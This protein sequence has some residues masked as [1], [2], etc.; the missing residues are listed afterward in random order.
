MMRVE[1]I[2]QSSQEAGSAAGGTGQSQRHGSRPG[3]PHDQG[4]PGS[5]T[6]LPNSTTLDPGRRQRN[7]RNRPQYLGRPVCNPETAI[8]VGKFSSKEK[9]ARRR[10]KEDCGRNFPRVDSG[11]KTPR[12]F[13]RRQ[14]GL[15]ACSSGRGK[16]DRR[17][18]RSR[19]LRPRAQR[20]Q[21]PCK[22]HPVRRSGE[23][24]PVDL[25]FH[26]PF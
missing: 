14:Q 4:E 21:R 20:R 12:K 17:K 16:S 7:P 22:E 1:Q 13:G 10:S 2:A 3:S 5:V 19:S 9:T 8:A 23:F 18:T 24:F 25:L 15:E 26:L 6:A 11:R